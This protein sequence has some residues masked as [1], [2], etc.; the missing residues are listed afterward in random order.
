V[1]VL[2]SL[3]HAQQWDNKVDINIEGHNTCHDMLKAIGSCVSSPPHHNMGGENQGIKSP[4]HI[5]PS[6]LHMYVFLWNLHTLKDIESAQNHFLKL[7][8]TEANQHVTVP[9]EL[10]IPLPTEVQPSLFHLLPHML[11][12]F[13]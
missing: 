8:E 7:V 2:N 4:S 6:P 12:K 3:D 5:H 1:Q 9:C 13:D 11:R 10:P